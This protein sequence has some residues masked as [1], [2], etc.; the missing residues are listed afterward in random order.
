[1]TDPRSS[2]PSAVHAAA[3]AGDAPFRT[4]DL[5]TLRARGTMKWTRYP[6]D[7]LP[8]WVAESDFDTC[9][10]VQ[11]AVE[12]AVQRQ[13]FGY[14]GD[15]RLV[16]EAVAGFYQRHFGWEFSPES[17]RVVP[18]VVKGVAVAVAE[19]TPEGSSVVIP[20]PSYYPFFDVPR[21]TN[22]PTV[23]V[24]MCLV[25]DATA[26]A[27]DI[28]QSTGA[29]ASQ[30][31]AFDLDALERAFAAEDA[32]Q[33]VGAMILCNPYNPL[34]RAFRPEELEAVVELADK[35]NVRLISDEIH[36]PI[37]YPGAQHT[38]TAS[39]SDK[40]AELTVTVTA[41][42]KGWNTAGL[43]CAQ[44]IFSNESDRAIMSKV[45][46]LRTGEASTLGLIAAAAAYNEGE[47]W[48][49]E[50]VDYLRS[51][52]DLLERR[53]PQVLPGARFIRPEACYLLWLD[54]SQVPGLERN[55]AQKILES[56]KVAFSEG[57]VFGTQ[58]EGHLRIN[59]ATSRDILNEALDR[60]AEARGL[61]TN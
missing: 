57:S 51:N 8:L 43:H 19:L 15:D 22:R 28:A 12:D 37:V 38:P 58:G 31:W 5:D 49:A 20:T 18:D 17:V 11:R 16:E 13:Y 33:P 34:G 54:V 56:A 47:Q 32:E 7:V 29:A 30:E 61:P 23:L 4:L 52:L 45:H 53:I 1:M 6:E 46:P 10:P 2:T 55:P 60:I 27:G 36:A 44:M 25:S 59:F 48:L 24:P 26:P 3:P 39:I 35:Y 40:A 42:S 41:T 14:K 9:P 50:E 21:A